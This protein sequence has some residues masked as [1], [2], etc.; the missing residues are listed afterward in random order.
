LQLRRP[1]L[2]ASE[3]DPL[4]L[5][6]IQEDSAN[7]YHLIEHPAPGTA[8]VDSAIE[9]FAQLLPLQD[10]ASTLKIITQ[11]LESVRSPKLERNVGRRAAVSVN[12]A[13][14]ML[15]ALRI[16]TTQHFRQARDTLGN[17][18][19]TNLLS[20]FLK[21]SCYWLMMALGFWHR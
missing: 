10:V 3:H 20:S 19:V 11:L 4:S 7:E 13:V 14:A 2:G 1:V 9:L 6:Q 12:A 17:M 5:C 16:A 15:L 18:Q 8:V 21:V